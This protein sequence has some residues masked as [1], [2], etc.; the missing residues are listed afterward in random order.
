[1]SSFFNFGKNTEGNDLDIVFD[2]GFNHF[3]FPSFWS[4]WLN[5][6]R[7][8]ENE[9]TNL[10]LNTDVSVGYSFNTDNNY[11]IAPVPEPSG[12]LLLLVG[13]LVMYQFLRRE[14][15]KFTKRLNGFSQYG[16]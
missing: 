11:G 2:G 16:I 9:E 3:S 10:D 15:T 4:Y 7:N 14:R 13:F 1:M 12:I 6:K 8:G 5:T